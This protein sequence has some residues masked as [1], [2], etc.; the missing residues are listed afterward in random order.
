MPANRFFAAVNASGSATLLGIV[1]ATNGSGA[2][3]IDKTGEPIGNAIKAAD[4]AEID[5]TVYDM[6]SE[7]EQSTYTAILA[8]GV[9]LFDTI[10]YGGLWWID[11]STGY[12]FETTVPPTAF[13]T[14]DQ[15]YRC[16]VQ[17]KA[18]D[19]INAGIGEWILAA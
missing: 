2:A 18:A 12:N 5:L 9:V 8:I 14:R 4:V 11:P 17:F 13:P 6:S 1:T 16:I 7:P 3:I 15:N 10:Q 19:G